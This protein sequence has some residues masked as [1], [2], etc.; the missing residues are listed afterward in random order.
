[1]S[2]VS[3]S[4]LYLVYYLLVI[5]LGTV[6]VVAFTQNHSSPATIHPSVASK[7]TQIAESKEKPKTSPTKTEDT[8]KTK[9]QPTKSPV[10]PTTTSSTTLENTGPGSMTGLF[11]GATIVGT[12]AYRQFAIRRIEHKNR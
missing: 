3:K 11:I 5:G 4:I 2:K 1:M 12:L 7:S 6:I 10:P 9:T 8:K